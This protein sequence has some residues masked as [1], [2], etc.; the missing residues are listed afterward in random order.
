MFDDSWGKGPCAF[1]KIPSSA[2]ISGKGD[3]AHSHTT[4]HSYIN[5][6]LEDPMDCPFIFELSPSGTALLSHVCGNS[7]PT[8]MAAEVINVSNSSYVTF[9]KGKSVGH[10]EPVDSIPSDAPSFYVFKTDIEQ[11]GSTDRAPPGVQLPDQLKDMH[12]DNGW[13][14]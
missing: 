5:V 13:M 7:Q 2:N 10:A 1:R 14:N 4:Q 6:C 11:K 12:R 9:K 3:Q 8:S